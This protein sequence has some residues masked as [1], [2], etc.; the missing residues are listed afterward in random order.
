MSCPIAQFTL[1]DGI[2]ENTSGAL[3]PSG[4]AQVVTLVNG[5]QRL[6]SPAVNVVT[7]VSRPVP[8]QHT[9]GQ[10]VLNSTGAGSVLF[11]RN[12]GKAKTGEPQLAAGQ[13]LVAAPKPEFDKAPKTW[14]MRAKICVADWNG[15]GW[16]DLLL[17]DF[18]SWTG[19]V[20]RGLT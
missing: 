14:G 3:V 2:A 7:S 1:P 4:N 12:I 10:F 16:P 17:G 9:D 18:N 11:Y 5:P 15:D 20:L 19:P 6:L 13:T 8:P